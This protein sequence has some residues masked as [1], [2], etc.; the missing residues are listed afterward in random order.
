MVYLRNDKFN[1][2]DEKIN[3]VVVCDDYYSVLL[4][5]F[6]KSIEMNHK[7]N[8]I[9]DVYIVNDSISQRNIQKIIDSLSLDK[10]TLNWIEMEDAIPK[11]MNLPSVNN[12]YPINTYI[13][14]LIPYFIPNSIE[15]VIFFDVDMI[16]LNDI[17]KLWKIDIGDNII[18][19]VSDTIGPVKKTIENGI[20]N[21]KEL[22]LNPKEEYFNAGLQIINTRKWLDNNIPQ[23]TFDIINN[24]KKYAAL[25]DQYGLNIA[26]IGNWYKIDPLWS[27]FSVNT[28]SDPHL[29]HYFNI[30]P[31]FKDYS[32][33]YKE[34]FFFYLNHT[35]WI[36]FKPISKLSRNIKKVRNLLKKVEYRLV[37]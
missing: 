2:M 18:G 22:G 27:C 8:E 1:E 21:Y 37:N 19:A 14:I 31:I 17:S 9:V 7:T 36:G 16:M 29:I 34:E 26:L 23:K 30:K 10:M 12:S 20:E 28:V 11:D 15:K 25:G 4:A 32:F 6:L 5:T 3:V 13:R 33:N 35:Q 24:N